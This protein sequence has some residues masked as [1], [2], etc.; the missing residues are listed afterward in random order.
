MKAD[1]VGLA[2]ILKPITNEEA[3]DIL[4]ALKKDDVVDE[5]D[6]FVY[7]NEVQ[8]NDVRPG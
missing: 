2:E 7:E 3:A 4:N 6:E 5:E 8:M 1:L